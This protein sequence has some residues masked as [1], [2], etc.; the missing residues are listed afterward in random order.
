MIP[1]NPNFLEVKPIF[2]KKELEILDTLQGKMP[3]NYFL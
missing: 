3:L 1:Y 2:S